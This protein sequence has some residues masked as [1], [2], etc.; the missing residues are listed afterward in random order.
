MEGR[1]DDAADLPDEGL[2][3][4]PPP[5]LALGTELLL[6]QAIF[7]GAWFDRLA[8][9]QGD[10]HVAERLRSIRLESEELARA[11]LD[12]LRL[13]KDTPSDVHAALGRLRANLLDDLLRLKE[14]SSEAFLLVGMNAP[15]NPLREAFVDLAEGDRRHADA[16]RE[17]LGRHRVAHRLDE[18]PRP[19]QGEA[20]G[21]HDRRSTDASLAQSLQRAL[22]ALRA[23][24]QRPICVVL[25]PVALR[26]ARDE[27]I[28]RAEEGT[29]FGLP[30]EIDFGWRGECFAVHTDDRIR[31]ADLVAASRAAER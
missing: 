22:D 29:L 28:V 6:Y 25:S 9:Q 10:P 3:G 7:R 26:H 24:G 17:L 5:L 27:G 12:A 31:L 13:W 14:A 2:R 16:L 4:L 21:A 18:P 23:D 15:T 11:A 8:R 20:V 19:H 30:V 1:P